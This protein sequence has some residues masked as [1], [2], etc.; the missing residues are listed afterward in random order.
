MK[1]RASK[2]GVTAIWVAS[3]CLLLATPSCLK[4]MALDTQIEAARD[5]RQAVATLHDYE[6][7]REVTLSGLGQ[8][9]MLHRLAPDNDDALFLLLQAWTGAASG[10]IEDELEAAL[11][12]EQPELAEYHRQ[13]AQAAYARALHYGLL[14]LDRRATGFDAVRGNADQLEQWLESEFDEQDAAELLLWLGQAWL[15][16]VGVAR[17]NAAIVAERYVGV[18][19][20]EQSVTLAPDHS[21]GLARTILAG[22]RAA[23]GDI[24]RGRTELEQVRAVH[25][26]RYL[27]WHLVA[28]RVSCDAGDEA[29]WRA[30]L[31]AIVAARDP[32]PEAR[33]QNVIAM[34]R[35]RRYL[36]GSRW[37]DECG[38]SD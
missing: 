5:A 12:S 31:E 34:R 18:A 7:A 30:T 35:A 36:T 26:G 37:R 8:L 1:S 29:A 9:E 28:A 6:I 23:S 21:Y 20:L 38:F 14:L 2:W 24:E 4:R 22:Y 3:A 16:R 13:R 15:G 33:L 25:Q 19:L 17:D 32:L 27:P 11:D 10:F